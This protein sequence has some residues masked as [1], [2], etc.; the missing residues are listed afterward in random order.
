MKKGYVQVT[1]SYERI[2]HWSLAISCLLLCL[3]GLGMMFHTFNFVSYLF[4]GMHNMKFVH[5]FTGIVFFIALL[6]AIRMWWRE[7]GVFVLPEDM[8]WVKVAGGYLWHVDNVPE[9]G[10][11]NP[12]QKAF[13]LA[14]VIFGVVMVITGFIMWFPAK[15]PV[16]LV[17]WM[18]PLHA[19]G[20]LAIF[21][22]FFVHLYLGTIGNPG[23]VQAMFSGWMDKKVLTMLHPKW[24]KEMEHEGKLIAWGEQK[25]DDTHGHHA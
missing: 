20:F 14:V 10:K 11:Y 19:L 13:Y 2:I 22:F 7:A 23:T 25:K 21:A 17:R 9:T 15:F 18:Y 16:G 6:L 1:D 4:G 8:E 5:N 3:T 12:G 24:V